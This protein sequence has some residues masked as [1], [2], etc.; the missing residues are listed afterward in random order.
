MNQT[1]H[2]C[3]P[4]YQPPTPLLSSHHS[5]HSQ[6]K[7]NVLQA[8]TNI[9]PLLTATSQSQP[10]LQQPSFLAFKAAM[11]HQSRLQL[12]YNVRVQQSP[13]PSGDSPLQ[14]GTACFDQGNILSFSIELCTQHDFVQ[15]PW[16]HASTAIPEALGQ[17][18]KQTI[19]QP[20]NS[21]A[22]HSSL[23]NREDSFP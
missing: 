13:R 3:P 14:I 9:S 17:V 18:K 1:H 12:G 2:K 8:V 21:S 5:L 6:A 19:T 15:T 16:K 10:I 7:N 22:L 23:P 11:G 20:T 4:Y